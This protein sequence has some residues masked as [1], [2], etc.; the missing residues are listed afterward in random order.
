[1]GIYIGIDPGLSGAVAVITDT[2]LINIYDTPT[3]TITKGAGKAKKNKRVYIESEMA[4]IL[5]TYRHETTHVAL[6]S[7]HAFPKQGGVS[8]FTLGE[9]YGLWRG[10]L[11]ALSLPYTLVTPNAWK[12]S[13]MAGMGK[14]KAASCVRAQQIYPTA[15]LF[16]K[17]GRAIDG[18]GDALLIA[19]YLKNN[20]HP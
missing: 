9:G 5:E 3:T 6:E 1:M 16:T 19:T 20:T 2:S 18:R 17:R 12:K 8:N 7:Q 13:L 15:E 10:M 4:K 11:A 14:E